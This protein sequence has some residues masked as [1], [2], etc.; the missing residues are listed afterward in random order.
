MTSLK[1]GE[2]GNKFS[3]TSEAIALVHHKANIV[4]KALVFWYNMKKKFD[5][6]WTSDS[7][8]TL[9]LLW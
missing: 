7:Y 4:T 9:F 2:T 6:P 3:E 8:L 5:F 1:E